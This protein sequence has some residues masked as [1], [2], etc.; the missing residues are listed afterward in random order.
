MPEMISLPHVA[1]VGMTGMFPM[2]AVTNLQ[3]GQAGN[4][5][6]VVQP[7]V[8]QFISSRRKKSNRCTELTAIIYALEL[9]SAFRCF[10]NSA[11]YHLCC[12]RGSPGSEKDCKRC[13]LLMVYHY[14]TQF[15]SDAL[16]LQV[17]NALVRFL[18]TL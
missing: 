5:Q 17:E 13:K 14:A 16:N 9:S 18:S 15:T 2:L 4:C 12:Q 8:W 6:P 10:A 11:T 3:V 1:T 7:T